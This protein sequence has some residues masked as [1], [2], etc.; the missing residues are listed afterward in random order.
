[1]PQYSPSDP[2]LRRLRWLTMAVITVLFAWHALSWADRAF[3]KESA[4]PRAVTA[5]GDLAADEKST[6]ELFERSRDSVVY[7]ST[8]ERV[9][10]FWS[11]NVFTIPRGTGSGFIWDDKGHVVTNY[12]VIDGASEALTKPKGSGLNN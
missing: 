10:D 2:F 6:I 3:P 8:S 5:R 12:H 9:M 4:T 1:M 11:R 7:I